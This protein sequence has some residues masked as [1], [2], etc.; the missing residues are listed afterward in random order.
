[1]K[2]KLYY[3]LIG[4]GETAALV[5]A[6]LAVAWLCVP[7]F[8][9]TPIVAGALDPVH[10][11]QIWLGLADEAGRPLPLTPVSQS[12]AGHS[13]ILQTTARTHGWEVEAT[14]YMPWGRHCLVREVR[15]V[16]ADL[17]APPARLV[18]GINPIQSSAFPLSVTSPESA[19][20][21]QMVTAQRAV[22]ALQ[23]T[24]APDGLR[25][26]IGYGS[27]GE[28]ALQALQAAADAS[29]GAEASHWAAWVARARKPD[30]PP[31]WR[32]SYFRSLITLRLLS[33][34]PTGALLAA[35]TASFPAVPGGADNWDYRYVWL[36]DGYYT[37]MTFD[38]AGF[39]EEARRF[40]DFAFTLQEADGHW[41]QPLYTVDG[42]D[43][44]EFI[45]ED[46]RGP[47]GE[48]PI[49]FGNAAAGQLQLDNE[50]NIL[51]GLWFHYKT[52]GDRSALE[53]HWE[54]VRRAADWIAANW[55]RPESGIWELRE[56]QAHWVHGKVMCYA[57]LKA[58]A[59]IAEE[60]GFTEEARRWLAEAGQVEA[61]V[62]T[63]GWNAERGAYLAHYGSETL[64]HTDISVLALA[65]Y[66]LLQPNDPRLLA[67]VRL[68]EQ[69]TSAGGL[70]LHGGVSRY[71]WAAVPFYLPTIWLARYYL[72][73]GREADCDRLLQTCLDCATGLGLMAEHFDGRDHSQWG[74]FPQ[75]FSHE[76]VARLILERAAG[77]ALPIW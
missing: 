71:D 15:L 10:G 46:L 1:M 65:F 24:P 2:T 14:D 42:A 31:A 3:G 34:E 41:R 39:H 54:G 63:N 56:Y 52:S 4:N 27:T 17:A 59:L 9:Q 73:A 29:V 72:M 40:Y 36:R 43:P 28:E 49:R 37:A 55:R 75:A 68:M 60:L 64:P 44:A 76:E 47:G 12:Y 7:R 18:W 13:A 69:P 53:R 22:L 25:L 67:T 62:I 21:V 70:I 32:E 57:A 66:G 51:H 50:G 8:D 20:G 38:A 61:D 74:N 77:R 26:V 35:P 45:A 30:G 16:Q 5:G 48:A 33:Y 23:A 11:G 58:G 19:P 6:D